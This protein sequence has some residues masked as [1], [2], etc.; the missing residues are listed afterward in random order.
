LCAVHFGL[1]LHSNAPEFDPY[2]KPGLK[3]LKCY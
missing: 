3:N 1:F 2:I